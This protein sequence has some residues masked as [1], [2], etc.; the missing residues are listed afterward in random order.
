MFCITHSATYRTYDEAASAEHRTHADALR[1]AE[2]TAGVDWRRDKYD[3]SATITR[4]PSEIEECYVSLLPYMDAGCMTARAQTPAKRLAALFRR[5]GLSHLCITDKNN[6]FVGL[7]TRR[8]LITPPMTPAA[9][10]AAAAEAAHGHGHGAPQPDHEEHA[11]SSNVT[12]DPSP[13]PPA[14][15]PR[16]GSNTKNRADPT[17]AAIREETVDEEESS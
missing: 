1:A 2:A 13:P 5:V 4:G 16:R 11:E 14:G 15:R 10:A 9:M 8:S 7:I 17:V 12:D 6:R 3:S